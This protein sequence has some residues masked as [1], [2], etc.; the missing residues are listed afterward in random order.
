MGIDKLV[1][2]LVAGLSLAGCAST[3]GVRFQ[4]LAQ[5]QALVRDGR[6]AL[7]SKKQN[8]IVM[9]SPAG[10]QMET[11]RRPVYVVGLFNNS[12]NPSDFRVADISVTQ[13]IAGAS[14]LFPSC[15]T[16]SSCKRSVQGRWSAPCWLQ[17]QPLGTL[18]QLAKSTI[19]PRRPSRKEMLRHKTTL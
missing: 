12:G 8:S 11:G 17:R 19:R 6:A 16:N 1:I 9:I 7:V 5:Q 14:F 4:A 3:E 10:R 15:H 2:C 13:S 18:I